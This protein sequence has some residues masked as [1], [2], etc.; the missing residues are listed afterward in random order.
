M[1]K[2][3]N[4]TENLFDYFHITNE[5]RKIEI[6]QA[7]HFFDSTPN[8][9][10][11]VCSF[12]TNQF[13]FISP[14]V[15]KVLGYPIDNFL[16]NGY[17]F[18][19]SLIPDFVI[20]KLLAWQSELFKV[21]SSPHFDYTS[22]H[23]FEFQGALSHVDKTLIEMHQLGITL[24]FEPGGNTRSFFAIWIEKSKGSLNKKLLIEKLKE[25]HHLLRGPL[26]E[27]RQQKNGTLVKIK[28]PYFREPKLT[29][30]EKE[31]LVLLSKGLDLKTI[32]EKLEIS[33]YTCESHRKHLFEKFEVHNVAELIQKAS[34][35]YWIE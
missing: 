32:S 17:R 21:M 13:I 16:Q 24:E 8:C 33:Y 5:A 23:L 1:R 18:L 19:F 2:S 25:F 29:S 6:H 10:A 30:R 20:P 31:L 28:A 4:N 26:S 12:E 3:K 34:K 22:L 7:L 35:I 27:T 15:E 14:K 11:A 9:F